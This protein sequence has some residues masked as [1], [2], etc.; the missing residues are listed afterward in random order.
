MIVLGTIITHFS[1]NKKLL[2]ELTASSAHIS[3][4]FPVPRLKEEGKLSAPSAKCKIWKH[5]RY[6]SGCTVSAML[7]PHKLEG[8]CDGMGSSL[9]KPLADMEEFVQRIKN[10]TKPE[11]NQPYN[12]H[13]LQYPEEKMVLGRAAPGKLLSSSHLSS[14]FSSRFCNNSFFFFSPPIPLEE[15]SRW[16]VTSNIIPVAT[17]GGTGKRPEKPFSWKAFWL[18]DFGFSLDLR[19]N[20]H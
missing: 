3:P 17:W 19:K 18:R 11:D 4:S 13:F 9:G 16:G 2:R 5:L 1:Y 7:N 6:L 20:C 15:K 14:V 12:K 10:K 8:W